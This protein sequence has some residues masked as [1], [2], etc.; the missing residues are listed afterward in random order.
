MALGAG[1]LE[2]ARVSKLVGIRPDDFAYQ[3]HSG[4]VFHPQDENNT[5]NIPFYE[6]TA[7]GDSI[8]VDLAAAVR[9]FDSPALQLNFVF[10]STSFT[11]QNA[12]GQTVVDEL[13]GFDTDN[14]HA[15]L[16]AT[17]KELTVTSFDD[18]TA[19]LYAFQLVYDQ[20]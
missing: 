6:V 14:F 16:A 17:D 20:E 2:G 13:S 4:L 11:V 10:G 19:G 1:L 15:S 18:T 7:A 12:A 8:T 9:E 5:G 3:S